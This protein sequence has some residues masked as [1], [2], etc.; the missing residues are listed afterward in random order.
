MV[1]ISFNLIIE[2]FSEM[3][4]TLVCAFVLYYL[5]VFSR[6]WG[7]F[8][9]FDHEHCWLGCEEADCIFSCAK[10]RVLK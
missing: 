4:C 7:R 8:N 2:E 1:F 6:D 3:S 9:L 10:A 5:A